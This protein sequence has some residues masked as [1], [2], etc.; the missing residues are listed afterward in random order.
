MKFLSGVRL[1]A[2][3]ASLVMCFYQGSLQLVRGLIL[4]KVCSM[5]FTGKI[6][7]VEYTGLLRQGCILVTQLNLRI[8]Y[9]ELRTKMAAEESNGIYLVKLD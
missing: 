2:A 7:R 3:E 6:T 9:K 4:L 8:D 5:F 1:F